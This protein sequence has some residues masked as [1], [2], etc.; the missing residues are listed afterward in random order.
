MIKIDPMGFF[1]KQKTHT[2]K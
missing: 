1:K 2:F